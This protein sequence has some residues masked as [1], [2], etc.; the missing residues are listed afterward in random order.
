MQP[1]SLPSAKPSFPAVAGEVD[2]WWAGYAGRTML[3]GFVGC[4]ILTA[5]ITL[6]AWA[7]SASGLPPSLMRYAFY[8]STGLLWALQVGLWFFRCVA[9]NYR[10]TTQRLYVDRGFLPSAFTVVELISIIQVG[11]EQD[12]LERRLGVGHL[13]ISQDAPGSRPLVLRGVR[14]PERLAKEIR[15]ARLRLLA[16]RRPKG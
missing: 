16:G 7:F 11:V 3:P 14:D 12:W 13:R 15:R 6:L 9:M 5:A 4:C 10:L 1:E 2:I 8:A